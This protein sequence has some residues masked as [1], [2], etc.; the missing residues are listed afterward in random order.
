MKNLLM[1]VLCLGALSAQIG[2]ASNAEPARTG[3]SGV[4]TTGKTTSAKTTAKTP[5][6]AT[7]K[8]AGKAAGKTPD[9]ATDKTATTTVKTVTTTT[10]TTTTTKHEC[11]PAHHW[12]GSSCVHNGEAKG[13]HK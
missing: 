10:T 13:H 2:C 9:K 8:A 3:G 1:T 6:K 12:D 4:K 5:G 7:G 11:G